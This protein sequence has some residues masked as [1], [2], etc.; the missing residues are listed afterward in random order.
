MNKQS[1]SDVIMVSET[2][3]ALAF[4]SPNKNGFLSLGQS[5]ADTG[6]AILCHVEPESAQS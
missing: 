6:A 1:S 3:L 2:C 5:F 4:I